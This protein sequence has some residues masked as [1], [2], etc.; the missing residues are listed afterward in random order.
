MEQLRSRLLLAFL[1]SRFLQGPLKEPQDRQLGAPRPGACQ[2]QEQGQRTA[3]QLFA[4]EDSA[5]LAA[6][7]SFSGSSKAKVMCYDT[8]GAAPRSF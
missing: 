8:W 4:T 7:R 3:G 2:G 5:Y 6:L 1:S